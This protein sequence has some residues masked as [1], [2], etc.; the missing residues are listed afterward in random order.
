M[1]NVIMEAQ[2]IGRP[3]VAT[4]AG[5]AEEIVQHGKTGFL[6]DIGDLGHLAEFSCELIL[7][8]LLAESFGAA[9][10]AH[11]HEHFGIEQF[12]QQHVELL[13]RYRTEPADLQRLTV[14]TSAGR[15]V[16]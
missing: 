13:N 14:P 1:P 3:V 7:N 9:S 2:A 8:P 15:K 12:A 10:R 6:A 16:A 4:R 5:A 11:V